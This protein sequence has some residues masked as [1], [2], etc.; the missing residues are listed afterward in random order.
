[1][2][3]GKFKHFERGKNHNIYLFFKSIQISVNICTFNNSFDMNLLTYIELAY[4]TLKFIKLTRYIIN[5]RNVFITN[6]RKLYGSVSI[7]W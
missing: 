1:M 7:P 6:I 5:S 3:R 2:I 4:L